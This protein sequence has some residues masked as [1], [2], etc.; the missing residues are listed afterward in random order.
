MWPN[1]ANAHYN[2]ARLLIKQENHHQ[3]ISEL[4]KST[5]NFSS[6]YSAISQLDHIYLYQ[7]NY[8]QAIAYYKKSYRTRA[9]KCLRRYDCDLAYLKNNQFQEV[10]DYFTNAISLNSNQPDYH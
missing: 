7:G 8:P 3:T 4:K 9:G 6:L 10:I 1:F 2:Y 5:C